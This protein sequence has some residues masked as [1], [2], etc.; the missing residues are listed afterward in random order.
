MAAR[1]RPCA[2]RPPGARSFLDD[3]GAAGL[4]PREGAVEVGGGRMMGAW[5]P[6]AIIATMVRCSSSVTPGTAAGG[7]RTMDVPGWLAGPTVIQRIPP[8][9][10]SS[11]TSEAFRD[12]W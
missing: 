3:V 5:L 1:L 10:T 7:S 9:P 4:Q 11:R 12:E 6:L 8:Y 2:A